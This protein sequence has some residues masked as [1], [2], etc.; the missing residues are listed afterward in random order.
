M[1]EKYLELKPFWLIEI[2]IVICGL[3]VDEK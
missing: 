3:T 1:D 2:H